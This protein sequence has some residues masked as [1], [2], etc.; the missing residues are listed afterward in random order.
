MLI[1]DL[2]RKIE[3]S[4]KHLSDEERTKRLIAARILTEEGYYD[5]RYFSQES[6]EKSKKALKQLSEE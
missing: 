5:K 6:V 3:E 2:I 1:E 4:D